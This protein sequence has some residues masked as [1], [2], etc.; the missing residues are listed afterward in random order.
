MKNLLVY[1]SLRYLAKKKLRTFLGFIAVTLGIALYVSADAANTSVIAALETGGSDLS[2]KA[3]WQVT[4]GRAVGIEADVLDVIRALEGAIAAPVIQ[5]NAN[6]VLPGDEPLL[7]LG[8]DFRTDAAMRLWGATDGKNSIDPAAA[9]ATLMVPNA[10]LLTRPVAERQSLKAG[11]KVT[12]NVRGQRREFFVTGILDA[13]GPAKVM[14]G[15]IG[16]ISIEAA[17]TLFRRPGWVDRIEVAGVSRDVLQAAVPECVIEPAHRPSTLVEDALARLRALVAVSVIAVLVGTFIIY[18]TVAISVVERLKEI[19]TLRAIG[20][21]RAQIQW[22]LI[23]EWIIIGA[24]GSAAGIVTGWLLAKALVTV[25]TDMLNAIMPIAQVKEVILKP[26]TIVFGMLLGTGATLAAAYFP[27]RRALQFSPVTI[28]RAYSYRLSAG[29]VGLFWIGV[30]CLLLA[31]VLI[32]VLR[33]HLSIGLASTGVFFV[34]LALALPQTVIWTARFVRPAMA[35]LFGVEG[36]LAADNAAKFPQR[37]ALT[38]IALGGSLAMMVATATLIGGFREACRRWLDHTLPFD[39]SISSNDFASSVYASDLFPAEFRDEVQKIDG[40]DY[41]YAVR[42]GFCDFE[43][44]D[45]MVL[46]IEFDGFTRAQRR[47]GKT[48]WVEKIDAD[49]RLIEKLR[50]GDEVAISENFAELYGKKPGDTI[51]IRAR[52]GTRSVKIA[53]A[54]EDYSWPRGVIVLDLEAYRRLFD[55]RDLT[56]IDVCLRPGADEAAVRR[57]LIDEFG[58]KYKFYL[59]RKGEVQKIAEDTLDQT[60]ALANVQV[61]IAIFIG[62]LG[63]FNTLL[64][65]VLQRTREV[66]LLRA[67]G[68]SRAQLARTVMAEAILIAV[69]G[70]VVGVLVGLGGGWYPLRLFTLNMTGYLGPIVV[71]WPHVVGALV[72]AFL[73]GALAAFLPARRASRLNVLDAIGYE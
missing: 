43:K 31:T 29:Y 17:Q 57:R 69:V 67:I 35:R 60:I 24:L 28:L 15:G 34:G 55:D 12:L 66:G 16:V 64:I 30:A 37:T 14:D 4:R 2:G 20:A 39:F 62:F 59:F 13:V 8:V 25:T 40:I 61:L 32:W 7:C 42:V 71:P 58:A 51:E 45:I 9:L 11:S 56:Y 41:A 73:I 50:S 33:R 23:T 54:V 6:M 26:S 53:T 49:P 68:M 46:A 47:L 44:M 19:G 1:F 36:F 27:A 38:V 70:G 72:L 5:S 65:S 10:I 48:P 3:E 52:T 21:S 63:I 18:N 22:T